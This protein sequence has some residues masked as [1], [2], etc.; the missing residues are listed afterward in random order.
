M[1]AF[2]AVNGSSTGIAMRE[3]T[4]VIRDWRMSPIGRLC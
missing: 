3:I 4:L 1:S 2:D